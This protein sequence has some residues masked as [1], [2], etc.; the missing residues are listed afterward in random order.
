MADTARARVVAA[1]HER[2]RPAGALVLGHSESL[3]Q[4]GSLLSPW[5]LARALAWRRDTE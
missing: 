2:L 5:P 1:I 4:A 3:L